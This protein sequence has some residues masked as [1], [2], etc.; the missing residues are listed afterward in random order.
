MSLLLQWVMSFLL[1]LLLSLVPITLSVNPH[2]TSAPATVLVT[3]HIIPQSTN[4]SFVVEIDGSN[5][6]ATSEKPLNGE[7]APGQ[8]MLKYVDLPSGEY[9][10]S[11]GVYTTEGLVLAAPQTV[12][13]N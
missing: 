5:Y 3:L 7:K 11:A 1:A 10:V 2:V 12:L 8:F 9:T 6:Y 4:R 13:V